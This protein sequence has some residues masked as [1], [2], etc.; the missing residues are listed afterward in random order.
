MV[1]ECLQTEKSTPYCAETKCFYFRAI[2]DQWGP[3][4]QAES[5]T[6]KKSPKPHAYNKCLSK[7]VSNS[8]HKASALGKVVSLE[9]TL[10]SHC[11]L[12]ANFGRC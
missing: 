3:E 9:A 12:Q 11:F 7:I 6:A 1:S 8:E 4:D 10:Q 2:D 5:K